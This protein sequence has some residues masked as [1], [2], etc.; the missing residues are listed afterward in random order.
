LQARVVKASEEA[1]HIAYELHPSM[2]EDLGLTASLRAL[3][4]DFSN[5]YPPIAVEF[6]SG[7]M[8]ASMPREL[9]SCVYRVAQESLRNIAKHAHATHVGIALQFAN[10]V[11]SLTVSDD[12]KGFDLVVAHGS[13]GLGLVSVEER[14]RL[15]HGRVTIT[16]Q[17]GRGARISLTLPLAEGVHAE[18]AH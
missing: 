14:A 18:G 7:S 17:P 3:C 6:T 4:K 1:R 2:L 13:G 8:P 12:G 9:A 11:V 10:G 16:A 5:E 15:L